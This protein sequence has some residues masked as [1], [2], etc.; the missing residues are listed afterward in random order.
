MDPHRVGDTQLRP[1]P[2]PFPV[3]GLNT[4]IFWTTCL[5]LKCFRHSQ[6]WS[7]FPT[8]QWFLLGRGPRTLRP[9][10]GGPLQVVQI[11]NKSSKM[12]RRYAQMWQVRHQIED[13]QTNLVLPLADELRA[14]CL[15][16]STFAL[17]RIWHGWG[18]EEKTRVVTRVGS[19]LGPT[20][21]GACLGNLGPT[22]FL[23]VWLRI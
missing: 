6:M 17:T 23:Q 3:H 10:P 14:W 22:F 7:L 8:M 21:L 11:C 2:K 16:L 15:R 19:S 20:I 4:H 12:A 18:R 1:F 13:V 5:C 9:L